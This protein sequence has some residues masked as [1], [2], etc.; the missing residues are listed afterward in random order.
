MRRRWRWRSAPAGGQRNTN[1]GRCLY[2][3]APWRGRSEA[4]A[5]GATPAKGNLWDK[6]YHACHLRRE[7]FLEHC[8]RRS[9]S[10]STS[11]MLKAKFSDALRS[12]SD[13]AQGNELLCKVLCH[14]LCC[15]IQS[16]Y[17][18][19]VEPQFE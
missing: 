2:G 11:S 6:Q 15:L 12:K 3:R 9:L 7:T 8:H 4:G 5:G 10:E 17:E 19:G 14:N 18:L 16:F 1:E 13:T